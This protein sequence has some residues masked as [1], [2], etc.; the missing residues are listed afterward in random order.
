MRVELQGL[1]VRGVEWRERCATA[2]ENAGGYV[3]VL[4]SVLESR[5][6]TVVSCYLADL[7]GPTAVSH[8]RLLAGRPRQVAQRVL[9][10]LAGQSHARACV[11]DHAAELRDTLG[12][13]LEHEEVSVDVAEAT[14]EQAVRVWSA[15][16]G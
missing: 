11:L 15:E 9:E 5:A 13:L 12:E 6:V 10:G 1:E 3:V 16:H 4:S 8:M 2:I 7:G 14:L